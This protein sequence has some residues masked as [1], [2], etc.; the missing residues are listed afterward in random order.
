MKPEDFRIVYAGTPDFAVPALAALIEAGYNVVAVYTQPDRRA[1]RGRKLQMSPVKTLAVEHDIKVEQPLSMREENQLELLQSYR[2]DLMIVAAF[3]QILPLEILNTPVHGCLN[4]H[5]SLLP[6]WRGAAPI[7]RAIAQGD[8]KSGVTIMQM[9]EGL[10]TGDMLYKLECAIGINTT[11]VE[12]HD[13]LAVLGA[14]ALLQ[15]L[16]LLHEGKLDPQ[17][18]SE[19]ESCYAAKLQKSE[20]V[21]DWSKP[22]L[23]IHRMVCAFNAWPVA[24]TALDGEIIRVWESVVP[25]DA[26]G[27]LA[28]IKIFKP[29]QV[30]SS[31]STIDVAT[32][33]G[34]LRLLK[35]Q[36]PGKKATPVSD[37]LNSR[38]IAP[39]TSLG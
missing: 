5:A 4:V 23:E 31:D 37:F 11:G 25:D 24:Q 27:R 17:V 39:G 16:K 33:D 18:Q 7:Q 14:D 36:P 15:T 19:S 13:K 10:D 26:D 30:I 2:A 6:R 21:I 35:L 38:K 8:T 20:A 29:G 22:A 34:V 28:E 9:A 1:G 32:G 12:L 3:G